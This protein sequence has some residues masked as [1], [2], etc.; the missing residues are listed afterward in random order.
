[1]YAQPRYICPEC[2]YIKDKF[3]PHA[4]D[5]SCPEYVEQSNG[6]CLTFENAY[7]TNRLELFTNSINKLT[8]ESLE[9]AKISLGPHH[10]R[11]GYIVAIFL[12]KKE[13]STVIV[14]IHECY[15]VYGQGP[16]YHYNNYWIT[17]KVCEGEVL[18]I[19]FLIFNP[20]E[21]QEPPSTI[22]NQFKEFKWT[23]LR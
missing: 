5:C 9:K 16:T 14:E 7:A 1:M 20:K 19:G 18:T 8:N 4:P 6:V 17:P 15:N 3:P 10:P 13:G 22:K 12:G 2:F 21:D 23:R 11:D